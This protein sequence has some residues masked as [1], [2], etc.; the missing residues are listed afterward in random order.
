MGKGFWAEGTENAKAPSTPEERGPCSWSKVDQDPSEVSQRPVEG[1][2][3]EK[4]FL[5][6]TTSWQ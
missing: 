6:F 2:T 1:V 4:M 3:Q 5:F